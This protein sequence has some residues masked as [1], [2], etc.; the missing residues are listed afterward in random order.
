[1]VVDEVAA[2]E[3]AVALLHEMRSG[4]RPLDDNQEFVLE[5]SLSEGQTLSPPALEKQ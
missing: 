2:G 3:R 1:M 4:K 5:L